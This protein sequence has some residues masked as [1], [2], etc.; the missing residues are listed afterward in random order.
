[1]PLALVRGGRFAP[2]DF[3][4]RGGVVTFSIAASICTEVSGFDASDDD[5]AS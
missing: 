1:M 2:E 4:A 3:D 5:S